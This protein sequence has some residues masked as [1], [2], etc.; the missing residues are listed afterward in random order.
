MKVCAMIAVAL[1]LQ[2]GQSAIAEERAGNLARAFLGT[3][4]NVLPRID[5]IEAMANSL[6]WNPLSG[7]DLK[8]IEPQNK[9]SITKGWFV[10]VSGTP[11]FFLGASTTSVDGQ[12]VSSC[13]IAN[14][15]APS[16]D[17]LASLKTFL[18]LGEPQATSTE[19]GIR[20]RVWIVDVA[21]VHLWISLSDS[22]PTNE[23][24]VTLGAM[25]RQ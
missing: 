6:K 5:K 9:S 10:G 2:S 24:G 8:A 14:P 16:D 21:A 11:P 13:S 1:V 23:P 3:C 19:G 7:D 12:T 20:M 15:E 4:V 17:V 25:T 22:S 18:K